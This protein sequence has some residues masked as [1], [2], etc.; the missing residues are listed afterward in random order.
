MNPVVEEDLYG[1]GNYV[2]SITTSKNPSVRYG[3]PDEVARF[4]QY[5]L[6]PHRND[7]CSPSIYGNKEYLQ[8]SVQSDNY[9]TCVVTTNEGLEMAHILLLAWHDGECEFTPEVLPASKPILT[10][11]VGERP[12]GT[13]C[14]PE[15]F[16]AEQPFRIVATEEFF[17]I[18][19]GLNSR[20]VPR[21]NGTST[22]NKPLTIAFSGCKLHVRTTMSR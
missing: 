12:T 16:Y 11:N 4:W 19:Q 17:Y 6:R 20:S 15:E 5:T 22:F 10:M 2:A 14:T 21:T 18:M 3:L 1:G 7:G 9:N 8:A 13:S